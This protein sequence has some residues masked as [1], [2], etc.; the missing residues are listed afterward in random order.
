MNKT[1]AFRLLLT[2]S[3]GAAFAWGTWAILQTEPPPRKARPEAP[4]PLV[5]VLP[6]QPASHV[7]HSRV[8]GSVQAAHALTVRPQ[9]GG[10]L[11]YLHPA[12]EPGGVIPAGDPLYRIEDSDYRLAVK[13]AQADIAKARADIAIEQGRRKVA[14]EELQLLEDSI[15]VDPASRD[16]ALRDPQLRQVRAELLRAQNALDQAQLQLDRSSA[17]L[18][19]DVVVLARERVAGEVVAARDVIGQVARADRF[20]ARLQVPPALLARLQARTDNRPGSQVEVMANG[21]HYPAEV[22]RILAELSPDSRLAAVIAEV[23]D[24]L[25]RHHPERAALLLDSYVEA[26]I[27]SGTLEASLQVPRSAMQDERVWVAD[28]QDLLQVRR[29][30]VLFTGPELAYLAPLPQGDRVLLNPPTG[31]APGSPVRVEVR[32]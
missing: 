4:I 16:L 11:E 6:S 24:P 21:T 9:V 22:T 17:S 5:Q 2:G 19:Y 1:L 10:R 30:Q 20:W 13:A 26:N 25:G 28:A 32:Q 8:H 29:A 3:L 12:F 7:L 31:L 14:A 18:P 23:E 15:E 27:A